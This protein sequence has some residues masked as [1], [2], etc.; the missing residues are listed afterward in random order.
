MRFQA[1]WCALL[2]YPVLGAFAA[3]CVPEFENPLPPS[4][5]LAP[6][7]Q[8]VGT[9]VPSDDPE[10]GD[11]MVVLPRSSG[12]VDVLLIS[13]VGCD[14]VNLAV[15][16]GYSS[17]VGG[18]R[19]LCLRERGVE[20][21]DD[22]TRERGLRYVLAHYRFSDE[23]E[24]AVALFSYEKVQALIA[25]GDL[26]AEDLPR[27]SETREVVTSSADALASLIL[28]RRTE[29]FIDST[30]LETGMIRVGR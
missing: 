9:W 27:G 18:D 5:G 25:S 19:F 2:W 7:E 15:F 13:D 16:E 17:L 1:R 26:S 22:A 3:S 6:D 30:D 12:W 20:S 21:H 4:E 29:A 28:R 10:G 8:L 24:L 11:R 23:G 14:G